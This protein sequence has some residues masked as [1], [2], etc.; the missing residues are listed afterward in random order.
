MFLGI[1]CSVRGGYVAAVEEARV[2]GLSAMQMLPYR[3][4]HV[5]DQSDFAAFRSARR[6]AGIERLLVHSRYLP[7]LATTDEPRRRNSVEHL[8]RELAMAAAL[9]AD[10]YVL[11]IGAYAPGSSFD[12]AARLFAR[13]L[14]EARSA[15]RLPLY[16]ENVPGGGRRIG[17]TP[18]EL[19][20]LLAAAREAWPETW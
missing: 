18:E 1:H 17:G 19:R 16:I 9:E 15:A 10:A 7:A 20:A 8:K 5:P 2:L 3:R 12:E 14:A 6:G 4:H 13:G 11:H